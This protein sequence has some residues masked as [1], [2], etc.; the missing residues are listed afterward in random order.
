MQANM[1]VW[2]SW[3]ELLCDCIVCYKGDCWLICIVYYKDAG[4]KRDVV[5]WFVWYIM[6]YGRFEE[7]N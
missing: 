2:T 4:G 5:G 7:V 6:L 3:Y 1:G